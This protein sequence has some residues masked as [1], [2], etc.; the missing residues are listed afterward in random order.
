MLENYALPQFNNRNLILQLDGAPVHFAPIVCDWMWIPQVTGQEE[1]GYVKD[2]VYS[3][4][5]NTSDELKA[6]ITAA[7]VNVT[8]DMLQLVWQKVD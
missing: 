2:Q 4:K 8:K 6:R 7:I 1:E 3:Q 5:V